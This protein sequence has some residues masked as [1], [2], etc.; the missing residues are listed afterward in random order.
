MEDLENV[1]LLLLKR[2]LD[3]YVTTALVQLGEKDNPKLDIQEQR[4]AVLPRGQ[5]FAAIR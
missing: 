5:A 3:E 2:N 4:Y 1:K